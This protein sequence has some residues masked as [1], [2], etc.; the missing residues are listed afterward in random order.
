MTWLREHFIEVSAIIGGLLTWMYHTRKTLDKVSGLEASVLALDDAREDHA[1]RLRLS[2][3]R[4][5]QEEVQRTAILAKLDLIWNLV[6]EL[7]RGKN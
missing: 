2:E 1:A 3:Q 7:A 6:F 5:E 4:S